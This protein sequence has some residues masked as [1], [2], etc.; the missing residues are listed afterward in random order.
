MCSEPDHIGS[1]LPEIDGRYQPEIISFN[2]ENNPVIGYDACIS[3]DILQFIEIPEY[4][5]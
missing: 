3:I 5:L 2:I 1:H 4:R